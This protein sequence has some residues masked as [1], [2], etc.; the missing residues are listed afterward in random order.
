MFVLIA[1]NE[2]DYIQEWLD[3]HI[4]QGV[5]NFVIYDNES[6]D[7]LR[8]VLQPYIDSGIVLYELMRGHVRQIDA[9]NKAFWKYGRRFKY[10]AVIDADEFLFVRDNNAN[11]YDF[12]DRFMNAHDNAG[13][14]VVNWCMFG[15]SGHVSKPLGGVL[16]NFTR[17]APDDFAANHAVKSI[18]DPLRVLAWNY[19]HQ[20]KYLRNFDSLD[21]NASVVKTVGTEKVS[22]E[23]IRINHYFS[24]SWEEFLRKKSRGFADSLR[25][26]DVQDFYANDRNEILDT[27][28]LSHV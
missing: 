27:E 24:K 9:Y 18:C 1:K 22:F 11:L 26:R 15:S 6:D 12:V 19:P 21:E 8:E 2:A 17:R 5:S 7:N 4:K 14:L 13:G 28:I 20:P 23:K 10:M 3:F 16:R 25:E